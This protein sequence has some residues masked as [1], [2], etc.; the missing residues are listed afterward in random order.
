MKLV[1]KCALEA[2]AKNL[3][4]DIYTLYVTALRCRWRQRECLNASGLSICSSVCPYVPKMHT[5]SR[6]S[7]KYE[8]KRFRCLC[9]KNTALYNVPYEVD[10]SGRTL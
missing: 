7:Q 10:Y 9:L 6:F 4:T 2:N 8:Y 1:L 5:K 3:N